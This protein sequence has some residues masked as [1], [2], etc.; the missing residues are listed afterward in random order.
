MLSLTLMKLID[1]VAGKTL[2]FLLTPLAR[3]RR[4]HDVSY[5]ATVKKALVIK[6]WGMGSIVLASPA[7]AEMKAKWP[8]CRIC[9]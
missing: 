1:N 5:P 7:L 4:Q 6:F 9:W 8:G 3:L 2:C